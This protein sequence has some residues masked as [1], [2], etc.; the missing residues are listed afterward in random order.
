MRGVD[1]PL[2]E[3]GGFVLIE[4]VMHAQGSFAA[5]EGVGEVQVGGRVVRRIAAEDHQ[6]IDFARVH[7][8]DEIFE[9][10]GL[11]DRIRIDGVGV[12][13]GLADVT[14]LGI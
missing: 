1:V 12:E 6:Q 2:A 5:F 3:F 14:E 8:G 9:R 11:I 7:V 4:T 13:N 10:V